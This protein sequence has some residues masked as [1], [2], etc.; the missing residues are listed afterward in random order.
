[1]TTSTPSTRGHGLRVMSG[2]DPLEE[3]RS[4]TP[5]ELLFDLTFVVAFGA[6]SN[7][8]AHLLYERHYGAALAAFT[9]GIFAIV[10]AWINYSW[11]AS[12]Y[13]TDDWAFRLATMVIMVGAV[14]LALGLPRLFHSI[15]EGG[16]VDN[17][18]IVLGYVVMRVAMTFL[19][20][21]AARPPSGC[22]RHTRAPTEMPTTP[23]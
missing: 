2:R 22:P 4:A 23:P 8:F 3:N 1:M 17:G 15:D 14:I 16:Y 13:D 9:L 20:L 18:V 19:W 10:W 5:L 7:E 12:A 6:A 21:R 11:F